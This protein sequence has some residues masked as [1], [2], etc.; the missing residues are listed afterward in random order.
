MKSFIWCLFI[1][2]ALVYGCSSGTNSTSPCEAV[3]ACDYLSSEWPECY[4][5][6]LN[7]IVNEIITSDEE[8]YD[9]CED[10]GECSGE[11]YDFCEDDGECLRENYNAIWIVPNIVCNYNGKPYY[12]GQCVRSG[13]P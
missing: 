10:D 7:E 8:N 1:L 2:V 3:C 4:D 5:E 9:F 13:S 6:D 12:Y 11:N